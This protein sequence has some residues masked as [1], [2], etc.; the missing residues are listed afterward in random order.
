MLYR[1][2][3][4]TAL[5]DGQP[6]P[7]L[8]LYIRTMRTSPH[9]H[10]LVR[11]LHITTRGQPFPELYGWIQALPKSSLTV[12]DYSW[13]G[14]R[15]QNDDSSQSFILQAPAVRAIRKLQVCGSFSPTALVSIMTL[16]QLEE[17]LITIDHLQKLSF[18]IPAPTPRLKHLDITIN[19]T[20]SPASFDLLRILVTAPQLEVL[21]I[22]LGS[23]G[24]RAYQALSRAL[25]S[26]TSTLKQ[27]GLYGNLEEWTSGLECSFMDSLIVQ[28]PSLETVSCHQGTFTHRFFRHFSP[29]IKVLNLVIPSP[30]SLSDECRKALIQCLREA[31]KRELALTRVFVWPRW[32]EDSLYDIMLDACNASG[33]SFSSQ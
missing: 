24:W 20:F 2:A 11:I 12:L 14:F 30:T 31:Q 27:F 26:T 25:R 5:E 8:P 29:V 6:G 21:I 17:L 7:W 10:A 22:R 19:P 28:C 16:S 4:L 33:I 23:L 3:D 13:E 18:H 32:E 15:G 9:L 1:H